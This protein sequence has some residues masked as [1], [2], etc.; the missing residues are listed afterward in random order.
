MNLTSCKDA[1]KKYKQKQKAWP[2]LQS[3]ILL[4]ISAPAIVGYVKILFNSN[5]HWQR[6]QRVWSKSRSIN[7]KQKFGV[8]IIELEA[9]FWLLIFVLLWLKIFAWVLLSVAKMEIS[10]PIWSHSH[11]RLSKSQGRWGEHKFYT[12]FS[13]HR[14][15]F[16]KLNLLRS[17]QSQ[18]ILRLFRCNRWLIIPAQD[19]QDF[20]TSKGGKVLNKNVGQK[21]WST[22]DVKKI[23]I[24]GAFAFLVIV[25]VS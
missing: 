24:L 19:S 9:V 23:A 8:Q 18:P 16:L 10:H 22:M 4:H 15:T 7:I 2:P 3:Q 14:P 11:C 25:S 20:D 17:L 5:R 21:C 1:G 13:F 6:D 12:I